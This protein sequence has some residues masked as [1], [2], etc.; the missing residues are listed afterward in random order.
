MPNLFA[1][2]VLLGFPLVALLMF[3]RLPLQKALV[4][5]VLAGHLMLP[6]ATMVNLPVLPVLDRVSIVGLSVFLL[7]LIYGRKAGPPPKDQR[8]GRWVF[9]LMLAFAVFGPFL[10]V[11]FNRTPLFFGPTMLPGLGPKDAVS[12]A[13]QTFTALVPF[14][15]GLRYLNTREG[16]RLLL[17]GF[18][19]GALIYT[20]PVLIELRLSPQLH[21]WVYGFFQHS[22]AQHIREGGFRPLVFLDH[23]LVL[24]IFLCIGCL[25]AL[26]LFKEALRTGQT[27]FG[28]FYAALWLLLILF[29]SNNFGALAL[30][31]GG[32]VLLLLSGQRLLMVVAGTVAVVVLL[33]PILRGSG[34]IPIETVLDL[35][36]RISSD[37]AGSLGF[38]LM[39]EEALLERANLKP[40]FGWGSWARNQIFDSYTGEMTSVTDGVWIIFIGIY[41]W[42]GYIGRFGL[43]TLPI[44]F[45]A[46]KRSQLGP[47]RITTGLAVV[48]AVILMDLIPNSA[49]V[50]YVW[51]MAGGI[52][53]L[54]L[55]QRAEA[56]T[57]AV[58]SD[59]GA[60]VPPGATPAPQPAAWLMR[61]AEPPADRR[62]ARAPAR[63][64]RS[65]RSRR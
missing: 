28:W 21:N 10:T 41:G 13:I 43:L 63:P 58:A 6:S 14:W 40:L 20:V 50:N 4:W 47:S 36:G 57:G 29:E 60:A 31:L 52:A 54:V 25:S 42:L 51:L 11:A 7:C 22:F 17:Q 37:R 49:L 26:V 46:A 5:S 27:A 48:L 24:G 15:L 1:Y 64:D 45:Y 53:G 61:P 18:V 16:H 30:A 2:I 39:N 59:T 38:R 12:L 3:H 35:L 56:A 23:G 65:G 32:S 19:I 8:A 34:L 62:A 55:T 33:Y 9:S 44:L